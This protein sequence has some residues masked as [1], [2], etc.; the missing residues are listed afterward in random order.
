MCNSQSEET[1]NES[2]YGMGLKTLKRQNGNNN[3]DIFLLKS[4][5][6]QN[7]HKCRINSMGIGWLQ[8]VLLG[9]EF[10]QVF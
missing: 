10:H 2:V 1:E 6:A 9:G 3:C 7:I 8:Q 4:K 5:K